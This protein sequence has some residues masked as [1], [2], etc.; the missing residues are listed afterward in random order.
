MH[1]DGSDFWSDADCFVRADHALRPNAAAGP[2]QQPECVQTCLSLPPAL[3]TDDYFDAVQV[4]AESNSSPQYKAAAAQAP[5]AVAAAASQLPAC[6]QQTQSLQAVDTFISPD[7]LPLSHLGTSPAKSFGLPSD[8]GTM[9]LAGASNNPACVLVIAQMAPV[10]L[11]H[12]TDALGPELDNLGSEEH[13]CEEDPLT[14]ERLGLASLQRHLLS[15]SPSLAKQ[16]PHWG[17]F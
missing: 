1:V 5:S 13:S 3:L 10:M 15:G 12:M 11:L 9:I 2:S 6:P 8:D 7:D 14:A 17:V 16:P 4:I